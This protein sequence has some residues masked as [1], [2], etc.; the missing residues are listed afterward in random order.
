MN[1]LNWNTFEYDSNRFNL[2]FH[3]YLIFHRISYGRT[4]RLYC[5]EIFDFLRFDLQMHQNRLKSR[6][7]CFVTV[8]ILKKRISKFN[9]FSVKQIRNSIGRIKDVS[10]NTSSHYKIIEG[11]SDSLIIN[12]I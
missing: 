1:A 4:M 12:H 8:D 3:V 10:R 9:L 2:M 5:I 11:L 6:V 7:F